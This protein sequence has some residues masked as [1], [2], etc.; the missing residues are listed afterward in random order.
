MHCCRLLRAA[1]GTGAASPTFV[2]LCQ[3]TTLTSSQSQ[4][5]KPCRTEKEDFTMKSMHMHSRS[6]HVYEASS[7]GA[8]VGARNEAAHMNYKPFQPKDVNGI[9]AMPHTIN[10]LTVTPVICAAVCIA[11]V[12]WGIFY[13]DVYCRRNYETVLIARPE[14][15]Q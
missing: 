11:C 15:L 8:E 12:T 9:L 7:K 14:E 1:R 5:D 4:A 3:K 6:T 10:L 13:W 2:Q